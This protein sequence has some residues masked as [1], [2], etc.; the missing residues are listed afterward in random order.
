MA[1]CSEGADAGAALVLDIL[2]GAAG[3]ACF[4]C[5]LAGRAV[6]VSYPTGWV[7]EPFGTP[8][9]GAFGCSA[10]VMAGLLV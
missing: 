1:V 9:V 4:M 5:V 10:W 2:V 8:W 3:V 7:I 6:V